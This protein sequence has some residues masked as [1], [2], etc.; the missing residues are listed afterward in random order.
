MDRLV[1][2]K[3]DSTVL[4]Y[5]TGYLDAAPKDLPAAEHVEQ[6][7]AYLKL[8]EEIRGLPAQGRII[9][10][11]RREVYPLTLSG[12]ASSGEGGL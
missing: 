9:Y 12:Q 10:L 6:L 8:M 7:R 2:S 3:K 1:L 11:D 5:K 4:E